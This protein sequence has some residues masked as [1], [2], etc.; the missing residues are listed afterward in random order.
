M[1]PKGEPHRDALASEAHDRSVLLTHVEQWHPPVPMSAVL[2]QMDP[3]EKAKADFEPSIVR[4]T[5]KEYETALAVAAE[6]TT[7]IG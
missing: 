1:V 3:S 4:I 6:H 5:A 7:T 2:A